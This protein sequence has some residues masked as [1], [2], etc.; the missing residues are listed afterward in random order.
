[1]MPRRREAIGNAKRVAKD[2]PVG[3]NRQHQHVETK[4]GLATAGQF[5]CHLD[6]DDAFLAQ[7][8]GKNRGGAP[9]TGWPLTEAHQ[10]LL[11]PRQPGSKKARR[12]VEQRFFPVAVV[13]CLVPAEF[14]AYVVQ[15][16]L[17]PSADNI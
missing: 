7:R 10:E 11:D 16:L 5:V 14:Q 8:L 17:L 12:T 9:N 6:H 4:R 1:M 13:S 2:I 15:R 3:G